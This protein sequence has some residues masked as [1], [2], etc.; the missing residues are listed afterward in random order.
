MAQSIPSVPM[1]PLVICRLV[2]PF[3]EEFVRKPLSGAFV[4][5]FRSG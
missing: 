4:N 2:R 1:P 5:Y 3:G